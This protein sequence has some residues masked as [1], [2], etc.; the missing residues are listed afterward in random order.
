MPYGKGTRLHG[1]FVHQHAIAGADHQRKAEQLSERGSGRGNQHEEEIGEIQFR[2]GVSREINRPC[3]QHR[4]DADQRAGKPGALEKW[5]G[6]SMIPQLI[7]IRPTATIRLTACPNIVSLLT[8]SSYERI[9]ADEALQ[10][11]RARSGMVEEPGQPSHLGMSP[12]LVEIR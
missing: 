12:G 4:V 7:R 3:H 1:M 5:R 6:K 8:R 9:P 11:N 2:T 10:K